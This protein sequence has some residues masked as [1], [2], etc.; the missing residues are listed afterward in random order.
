MYLKK[1]ICFS[2]VGA[3]ILATALAVGPF[4][5]GNRSVLKADGGAPMPPPIPWIYTSDA[6]SLVGV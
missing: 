1:A 6:K 2:L 4:Q 3:A 5:Q